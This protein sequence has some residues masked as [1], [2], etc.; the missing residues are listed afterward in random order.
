M[1]VESLFLECAADK[2]RE[3]TG[4]IEVC[5]SKLNEDRIWARGHEN[6]NAIGNLVL[7]LNGN[8]RQWIISSLGDQP[9]ERIR[10]R[11]FA[12]RG[13]ATAAELSAGLRSTVDEAVRV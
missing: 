6:E 2:L 9:D 8:M 5:L 12:A 11:E 3:F 10:D 4:R 1:S 7:H 13:G